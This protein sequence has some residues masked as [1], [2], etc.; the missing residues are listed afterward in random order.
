[1]FEEFD[2]FLAG[3][4]LHLNQDLFSTILR[5]IGE[6][7]G[8]GV[9]IHLLDDVGGAFGVERF[10]NRALNPGFDLFESLG[11]NIFIQGAEDSLTLV[12]SKVFDDIGNV[13]G[14]QRGQ[15]FVRNLEF[16]AACGI[17]F[18]EVSSNT[19]RAARGASPRSRRRIAPRTP[20]STDWIRSMA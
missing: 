3:L 12:G 19:W 8:G 13:G 2:N 7:V 18:D 17:S 15:A 20:I 6:K 5:E 11:C 14:M 16:N 10:D 1:M 4:R 9:G